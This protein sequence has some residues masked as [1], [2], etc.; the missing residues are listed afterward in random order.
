MPFSTP[1]PLPVLQT[2]RPIRPRSR[3]RKWRVACLIGVHVVILAHVAHWL[4]AGETLA[5][6]VLSNAM[7]TL[8][9]GLI[10]PAFVLFI[11]LILL[12][13]LFGRF[14]CGWACHM[15]ALQDLSYWLLRKAR[16]R[17]VLFRTR[18]L[19]YLPLVFAFY[20]FLWPT[21]KRELLV[22]AMARW[23]PDALQYLGPVQPFPGWSTQWTTTEMWSG[24]PGL[25][26]AIFFLFTCGVASVYFL[27]AR[28]FCHYGCPYGGIFKPIERLAAGRIVVDAAKCDQC[29]QCTAAC[30]SNV[31]VL[32]ELQQHG[33]VVGAH[34]TRNMDCI[35]I[36]PQGALS[37]RAA[38]PPAVSGIGLGMVK[39]KSDATLAEEWGLLIVFA[40][41]F[42]ITR[43]LYNAVPMLFAV[44]LG[45]CA[46]AV[47]WKLRRMLRDRDVRL[48]AFQLKRAGA[49]TK[50]GIAFVLMAALA[51]LL[52]VQGALVKYHT[53][54]AGVID[55]RV[56]VSRQMVFNEGG[57]IPAEMR[58]LAAMAVER[59][60]KASAWHSGGV[61]LAN[62]PDNDLRAAWL[63]TVLG[64]Y[65]EA[66]AMLD[67][68]MQ[69]KGASG[70]LVAERARLIILAD[71]GASGTD[72]AIAYLAAA[73]DTKPRMG[74]AA[75][76]L[77]SLHA[78]QGDIRKAIA[79]HENYLAY[80]PR[81]AVMLASLGRLHMSLGD[82]RAAWHAYQRA[83]DEV[84][85]N[86]AMLHD[87]A[88]AALAAGDRPSAL[89]L[90]EQAA[91]KPATELHR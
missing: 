48:N 6:V 16:V 37:F 46:M 26:T 81:D 23:W 41:V 51:M 68:V 62:T 2:S 58:E 77:A 11:A 22:P 75:H 82:A 74:E 59:Y 3:V 91:S 65:D 63:L 5:P 49:V 31:D 66:A 76:M 71:R 55:S 38:Q 24:L 13:M 54:Q 52:T 12:T 84:P 67:R 53:W 45:V 32:A 64:P 7:Y 87:A 43:G 27:G 9:L 34:C 1:I 78:R 4:I 88:R 42:F 30:T 85:R 44:G 40:V 89:R 36:C 86:A 39:R 25:W 60:R 79:V 83:A 50:S 19:V 15:G 33:G 20:M 47:A 29:G 8:E 69:R 57:S 28:G 18:L 14:F 21:F 73:L 35:S 10:N 17:P 61:G 80:A 56:T 72:A 70:A 90:L